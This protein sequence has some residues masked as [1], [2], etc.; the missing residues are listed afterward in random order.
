MVDIITDRGEE[1][2]SL[3]AG[4]NSRVEI[5]H[6]ALGDGGGAAYDPDFAQTALRGER[7]RRPID[8]RIYLGD[9]S[10]Q[11][12]AVFDAN[13]E[14]FDVFEIGFFDAEGE[15]IILWAGLDV[16]ARRTGVT[17]YLVRNVINTSRVAD[18]LLVV[19]AP[20]DELYAHALICAIAHTRNARLHVQQFL[21]LRDLERTTRRNTRALREIELKRSRQIAA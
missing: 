9:G 11:A 12:T 19:N 3:A 1:K 5:T 21:K 16:V 4:S 10:W 2:L 18:G 14:A 7:V 6:V 8:S 17:E 20:D 15:L 13:T